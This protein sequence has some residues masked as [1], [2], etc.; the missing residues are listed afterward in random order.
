LPVGAGAALVSVGKV[1]SG[2]W[3][4]L[5]TVC[6]SVFGRLLL[7]KLYTESN[8][9]CISAFTGLLDSRGEP[10]FNATDF[11]VETKVRCV[12]CRISLKPPTD[13]ATASKKTREKE[14]NTSSSNRSRLKSGYPSH[15]A[16]K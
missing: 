12:R 13:C 7:A 1:I 10:A 2:S 6:L 3:V 16:H 9:R 5:V 11:F 8:T 15:R 14:I 4:A